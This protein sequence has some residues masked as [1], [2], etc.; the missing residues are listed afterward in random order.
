MSNMA[1]RGIEWFKGAKF[2]LFMHYGLYSLLGRGE[3]VQWV[4]NIPCAEYA[5]LMD[6]FTAKDF[7]AD[8]ITDLACEAEMKYVN[9]TSMHHDGFCLF[10]SQQTDFTST[11]AA[12][13]RD[14]IAELAE[15]CAAKGLGLCLY[16]SHGRQWK[17]PHGMCEPKYDESSR[18][19]YPTTDPNYA[20]PEEHDISKYVEHVKNQ[21]TEL[22]TNYGPIANIWFDGW[23]TPYNGPWREELELPELYA[24]IRSL[25]PDCLISYK[26]NITGTEDFYAPEYHWP[27]GDD[28]QMAKVR[29]N[30]K[31]MELCHLIAGWAYLERELGKH[32]GA[33]SIMADFDY[34][35]QYDANLLLGTGPEPTGLI[36]KQDAASLREVGRRLRAGG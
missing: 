10:E 5:K 32:R 6:D 12:A 11:N 19:L 3:W 8:A 21:M 33:D 28:E 29:A 22:L 24:H 26:W 16:Y 1:P 15:Q 20:S 18:P 31:P 14:L 30:P 9:I 35:A 7:D 25:Q 34:V 4:E 27:A 13:K 2:G 36:D 17:H 23:S